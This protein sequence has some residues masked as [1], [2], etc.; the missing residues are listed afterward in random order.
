MKKQPASAGAIG[1]AA[2]HALRT[3][4]KQQ[5]HMLALTRD[6]SAFLALLEPYIKAV[7]PS[8]S[9]SPEPRTLSEVEE[10]FKQRDALLDTRIAK[11]RAEENVAH[12]A[13][14]NAAVLLRAATKFAKIVEELK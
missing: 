6:G 11:L 2:V 8:M 9:N 12:A 3:M 10:Y 1:T 14:K 7:N 13:R 5:L 4:D